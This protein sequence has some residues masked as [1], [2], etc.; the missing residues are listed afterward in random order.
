MISKNITNSKG[1]KGSKYYY[2]ARIM[3]YDQDGKLVTYSKLTQ[4]KYAART[5]TKWT[6]CKSAELKTL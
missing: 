1:V 4:C 6:A 5:W 3:A 2:K